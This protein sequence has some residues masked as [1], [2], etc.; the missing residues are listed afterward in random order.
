MLGHSWGTH[1]HTRC[2]H[3]LG[4]GAIRTPTAPTPAHPL[5]HLPAR[6]FLPQSAGELRLQ[7]DIS[8]LDLPKNVSI[9]FPDGQV[10]AGVS[11]LVWV[12]ACAPSPV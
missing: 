12:G 1:P 3:P 7:K 10:G 8:E 11:S 9:R 2:P 4:H 6:L 5:A